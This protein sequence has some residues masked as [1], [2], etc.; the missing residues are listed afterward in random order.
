ME[1]ETW[2]AGDNRRKHNDLQACISQKDKM[3]LKNPSLPMAFINGSVNF[4]KSVLNKHASLECHDAKHEQGVAVK[5]SLPLKHTVHKVPA[6][7][8][9]A[10]GMH[11]LGDKERAGVTKLMD[12]AYFIALKERLFTDFKYHIAF[13]KLHEVKF[14][15]NSYENETECRYCHF[16]WWYK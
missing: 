6:D 12:I 15:V 4:K 7:S 13:E 9:I 1:E 14:D 5:K 10:S 16:N 2:M 8:A 3:L 11:K